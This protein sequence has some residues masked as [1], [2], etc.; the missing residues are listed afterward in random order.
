MSWFNLGPNQHGSVPIHDTS[1]FEKMKAKLLG[2]SHQVAQKVET[3]KKKWDFWLSPFSQNEISL[4]KHLLVRS[5]LCVL[6]Y[7]DCGFSYFD[8]VFSYFDCFSSSFDCF[9]SCSVV[10]SWL[11]ELGETMDCAASLPTTGGRVDILDPGIFL[12]REMCATVWDDVSILC[13]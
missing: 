11:T 13:S 6:S 9:S 3:L 4:F 8:S 7:C 2:V 10:I 1:P 12:I 5:G